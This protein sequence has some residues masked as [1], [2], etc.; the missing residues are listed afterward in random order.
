MLL[1]AQIVAAQLAGVAVD[2][3]AEPAWKKAPAYSGFF[4]LGT[5]RPAP[6]RTEA[7]VGFDGRTLLFFVK[8][9]DRKI[10]AQRR[11]HDGRVWEDDSVEVFLAPS[12]NW[13]VQFIINAEGS[14]YEGLG[15]DSK[16]GCAWR[17]CVSRFEGGWLAEMAV[18]LEE[19]P[20]DASCLG[21]WKVNVCR[22]DPPDGGHY[23]LA[24]IPVKGFHAPQFF[25]PLSVRGLNM[26]LLVA[27]RLRA[28]AVSLAER[29]EAL[30]SRLK[31]A[32]LDTAR[33][34]AS[35]AEQIG[36][37]AAE[38]GESTRPESVAEAGRALDE[39]ARKLAGL[40]RASARVETLR[41]AGIMA[42]FY[43]ARESTMT[44][45][46]PDLPYRG[47]PTRKASL[48][49]AKGEHEGLQLVIVPVSGDLRDV[50]LDI[51]EFV[52]PKGARLKVG[53]YL[54][55][56]VKVKRPTRGGMGLGLYPDPLLPYRGPFD[57]PAD[58]LQPVWLDFYAPRN[59]PA[60]VYTGT[61]A[62]RPKGERP[63]AVEVSVKVY[64]FALPMRPALRTS[65]GLSRG[66]LQ[67]Y[68]GI[69]WNWSVWTGADA[70]GILDY[71]GEGVFEWAVDETV[72]RSGRRSV[73]IVGLKVR[74]GKFEWPRAALYVK[75]RLEKGARYRFSVWYRT[76]DL[77]PGGGNVK[78]YILPGMLWAD[79][80]PSTEWRRFEREFVAKTEEAHV[81]LANWAVGTVWF[82]DAELRKLP[83]G[84]NLL[85]NPSFERGLPVEQAEEE[86]IEEMLRHRISPTSPASPSVRVEGS[87]V[88]IDWSEFDRR[89]ERYVKMGLTGI[90]VNW[91]R[92]P[93]GWGK[94]A[95]ATPEQVR[96]AEQILRLTEGHLRERGWLDLAYTYV[97]DEPSSKYFPQVKA[98]F[99]IVKRAS[100]G[101]KTLLTLGYGATRPWRP[102]E[103]G[104]PAY[105]ELGG[106]VD[107]WVPHTDCFHEGFMEERRRAGEEI[108]A[109]V[110]ISAQ[111]PYANI[112]AIDYPG[113]D[114]RVL[115]W[116]LWRYKV[117]GFLYWHVNY[118]KVNPWEET[119]TYPG[120]N[121]DGSLF[122]PGEVG[123][124]GS[125]RLE[126]TRDGIEDYDY[127]ALLSRLLEEARKR[128]L[129]DEI[130]KRAEKLLD[131]S[132]IC[133]SWTKYTG[134]PS[135][136]ET[137][138]NSI[139][140]A[141]EAIMR[142]LGTPP[143]RSLEAVSLPLARR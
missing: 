66:Y 86:Y 108:W 70:R 48:S 79:L 130:V 5:K 35:E 122:Y 37:K 12:P 9:F 82:D 99:S 59:V 34:M 94:V 52:G 128:G 105:A 98:A 38:V 29:A 23:T 33:K 117:R 129:E 107:I 30:A 143:L 1:L 119:I 75:V 85:P 8:C 132:D 71:F 24:F 43:V 31:A 83:S 56:F 77:K 125:I 136:I 50:S 22:N 3:K 80:P 123:P 57:V 93:G 2:G 138:R 67:Q 27:E 116:Q 109:Y 100:P 134:E 113:T 101:I 102:G 62:V 118:W 10:V 16:W 95:S 20:L 89:I 81:Y 44:K 104:L 15:T 120:G 133:P 21:T 103:P 11:P 4:V 111:K 25:L 42:N 7:R 36:R 84:G 18:P 65:F 28:R 46:R 121:G 47:E 91:A 39:L 112:W 51:S 126:L 58:S 96:S 74:K 64:N 14:T 19:L 68:H 61:V 76:T 45:V 135:K 6:Q 32:G 41:E 141:I 97:I 140:R 142:T 78:V 114:H 139:A 127:L 106:F 92:L 54:V 137:K 88:K 73:K 49:L 60:G 17:A 26:R 124:V 53:P 115:F 72:A 40:E 13:Y 63:W 87:R 90:N 131:V 110:C 55:G 69:G